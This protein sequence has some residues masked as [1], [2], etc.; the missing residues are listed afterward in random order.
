M[1]I[2]LYVGKFYVNGSHMVGGLCLSHQTLSFDFENRW[3]LMIM[4]NI[5]M[6]IFDYIYNKIA[7]Q[8]FYVFFYSF[9]ANN[10]QTS[11]S[12]L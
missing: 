9:K 10:D 12:N 11:A 2:E 6:M 1:L 3:I 5:D 7:K 8:K 4:S